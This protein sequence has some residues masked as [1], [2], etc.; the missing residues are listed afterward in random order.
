VNRAGARIAFALVCAL[1]SGLGAVRA[2]DRAPALDAADRPARADRAAGTGDGAVGTSPEESIANQ[3]GVV[4]H[5]AQGYRNLWFPNLESPPEESLTAEEAEVD[6]RLG[7]RTRSLVDERPLWRMLSQEEYA[8]ARAWLDKFRAWHP[9]WEPSEELLRVLQEGELLAEIAQAREAGDWATIEQLAARHPDQ[10]ACETVFN[11]WALA[12]ARAARE[13][14]EAA[15]DVYQEILDSCPRPVDRLV[16]LQRAA[17][18]IGQAETWPLVQQEARR[19]LEAEPAAAL[20]QFWTEF[21]AAWLAQA[22]ERGAP[23]AGRLPARELAQ[24]VRAGRDAERARLLGWHA[25]EGRAYARA[26]RWFARAQAWGPTADG[27]YGL[28]VGWL[29]DGRRGDAYR[30]ARTWR[31]KDPRFDA[32]LAEIAGLRARRAF[33]AGNYAAALA[34]AEADL[35][36]YAGDPE[37][38]AAQELRRIRGWSLFNLERTEEALTAFQALYARNPA[39]RDLAAAVIYAGVDA[40]AF[41]AV[42][43][44]ARKHGGALVPLVLG[45]HSDS[46]LAAEERDL[47]HLFHTAWFGAAA[48]QTAPKQAIARVQPVSDLIVERRDA[49]TAVPLGWA[50]MEL[51]RP[52]AA[53]PWFRRALAWRGEEDAAVGLVAALRAE[54]RNGQAETLARAWADRSDVLA[55]AARDLTLARADRAYAGEDY[56]QALRLAGEARALAG[57][58]RRGR[59]LAAWSHYQLGEA[60]RSADLFEALYREAPD[61]ASGEG[62]FFAGLEAGRE[63]RLAELARSIDGPLEARWRDHLSQRYLD[64]D[65][66]AESARVAR[67]TDPR[68]AGAESGHVT[69]HGYGRSRDGEPGE[70]QLLL[71]GRQV[72][73]SIWHGRHMIGAGVGIEWLW[74]G[75]AK[76]ETDL[77][78]AVDPN[79]A[80]GADTTAL[81]FVPTV[82]YAYSWP[83]LSGAT[84]LDVTL[85]LSPIGGA[86]DPRPIGSIWLER[87]EVGRRIS[88]ELFAKPR[89]DSLLSYAGV[90]DPGGDGAFGRVIET[91]IEVFGL[92]QLGGPWSLDGRLGLSF[93]DGEKVDDNRRVTFGTSLIYELGLN[94]FDYFTVGPRYAFEM[95]E[96]NLSR[97]TVGHGGYFS[98]QSLHRISLGAAFQTDDGDRFVLRGSGGIGWQ[99]TDEDTTVQFPLESWNDRGEAAGGS[100]S[101]ALAVQ[102]QLDGVYRVADHVALGFQT[103]TILSSEFQEFGLGLFLRLSLDDRSGA[104][105]GDIPG[106]ALR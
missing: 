52:D 5:R 61:P 44:L 15:H 58:S 83:D 94:G 27:A 48:A 62:L 1:W 46:D 77:G 31:G 71:S 72:T 57:P 90:D 89:T 24:I 6:E 69:I 102:A 84:M 13:G 54:N 29:R 101:S 42:R 75:D 16:T 73:G 10:F 95:N 8:N 91:G 63:A 59:L 66:Y 17:A 65:L 78:T 74:S 82:S 105:A 76:T 28:A 53:I 23:E 22:I 55:E 60:D 30:V 26:R 93:L 50:Y 11:L 47:R 33:D 99:I 67:G 87:R 56:R 7:T 64:L 98:P 70:G 81:V 106:L 34:Y 32:L 49:E 45:G 20:R 92:Q 14:P 79:D 37:A 85:G 96:E 9:D 25:M 3:P 12:E 39:D 41:T 100:Q 97:F 86:V 88:L 51:D 21:H 19:D 18:T 43:D 4:R 35:A 36:R 2:Q 104:L 40:K 80:V 68:I 38:P 103:D